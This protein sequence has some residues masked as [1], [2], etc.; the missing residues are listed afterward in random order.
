MVGDVRVDWKRQAVL[1]LTLVPSDP[2]VAGESR[3]RGSTF[4]IVSPVGE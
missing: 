3:T 2:R 4:I 1:Y